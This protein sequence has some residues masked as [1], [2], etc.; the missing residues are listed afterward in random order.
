MCSSETNI[1]L[2]GRPLPPQD[3]GGAY[4]ESHLELRRFNDGGIAQRTAVFQVYCVCLEEVED[5]GCQV[6]Q[7]AKLM[8]FYIYSHGRMIEFSII[9]KQ[10]Q[11]PQIVEYNPFSTSLS[12]INPSQILSPPYPSHFGQEPALEADK[13]ITS[14]LS[15]QKATKMHEV[16]TNPSISFPNQDLTSTSHDEPE[17]SLERLLKKVA[18]KTIGIERLV[19]TNVKAMLEAIHGSAVRI[20]ATNGSPVQNETRSVI[21]AQGDASLMYGSDDRPDAPHH[22]ELDSSGKAKVLQAKPPSEALD[23]NGF[24]EADGLT[25]RPLV[26]SLL[27]TRDA[28]GIL[29]T[30]TSTVASSLPTGDTQDLGLTSSL[31]VD[32]S[33]PTRDTHVFDSQVS[34][35]P[36]SVAKTIIVPESQDNHIIQAIAITS[37]IIVIVALS[38]IVIARLIRDPRRRA[39]IA[40]RWEERRNRSLYRKAVRRQKWRNWY[41]NV[42]QKVSNCDE[43]VAQT[44]EEKRIQSEK[45]EPPP[46]I[47]LRDE[48]SSIRHVHDVID[49]FIRTGRLPRGDVDYQEKVSV[50]LVDS[51]YSDGAST[52][53][54]T[55][56]P[57]EEYEIY[58]QRYAYTPPETAR[59]SS[60]PGSSVIS[61]SPRTSVYNR[62]SDDE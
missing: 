13:P 33:V 55:L 46:A 44:W 26:S 8:N 3:P 39:D 56:P 59:T 48:I 43:E 42:R 28:S 61:T 10:L 29:A 24:I 11:H 6:N 47:R 37:V 58:S 35:T 15:P 9:Y 20:T 41:K 4:G 36:P 14:S 38:G 53:D 30:S 1:L 34:E 27:P 21:W 31:N 49:G 32:P 18:L 19:M 60:E 25:R 5:G 54:S 7:M 2:N 51:D 23:P 52:G 57:Y 17:V 45:L 16:P 50:T 12:A 62:D 40:A 22:E